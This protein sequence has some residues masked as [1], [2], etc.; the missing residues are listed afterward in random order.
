MQPTLTL[1]ESHLPVD[2]TPNV[3][4]LIASRICHDL[5]SPIGAVTNGLELVALSGTISGEEMT[6]VNESA[7]RA[8]A[9]IRLFRIAFGP[10]ADNQTV[11]S[12][13]IK[14]ILDNVYTDKIQVLWPI[15]EPVP[16]KIAQILLLCLTCMEHS[17]P[18]GGT[19]TIQHN[20]PSWDITATSTRLNPV[21]KLWAGLSGKALP[22]K[23]IAPSAVQFLLLPTLFDSAGRRC[24]VEISQACLK[25]RF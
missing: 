14:S 19:I 5:I 3:A 9:R 10:A 2:D 7:A 15:P 25:I 12:H 22:P 20:V 13:E 18:A 8:N 4:S 6:L 1:P 11:S 16:R 24:T 23:E 17:L 21:E